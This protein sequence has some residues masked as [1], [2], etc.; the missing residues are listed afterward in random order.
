M[1]V[2]GLNTALLTTAL[3]KEIILELNEGLE[4]LFSCL[5]SQFKSNFLNQKT[6]KQGPNVNDEKM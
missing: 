6:N 2:T 1:Y 3:V 4:V 5:H